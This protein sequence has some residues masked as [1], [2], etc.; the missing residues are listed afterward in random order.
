MK[1]AETYCSEMSLRPTLQTTRSGNLGHPEHFSAVMRHSRASKTLLTHK[2]SEN[3]GHP[4]YWAPPHSL[5]MSHYWDQGRSDSLC[6]LA[7]ALT[8]TFPVDEH[9]ISANRTCLI[10]R[11]QCLFC[12]KEHSSEKEVGTIFVN[13]IPLEATAKHF[14]VA[15][16]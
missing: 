14:F 7:H 10:A 3:L 13:T 2:R 6:D 1:F 9:T 5:H 11:N 4:G 16:N 12:E 15:R 8:L